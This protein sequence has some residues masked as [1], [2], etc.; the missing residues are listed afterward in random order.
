MKGRSRASCLTKAWRRWRSA[1]WDRSRSL[2]DQ[3]YNW[4]DSIALFLIVNPFCY[5]SNQFMKLEQAPY[6]ENRCWLNQSLVRGKHSVIG[7]VAGNG[8]GASFLVVET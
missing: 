4:S 2:A 7:P 6:L 1:K 8:H 3:L 5:S